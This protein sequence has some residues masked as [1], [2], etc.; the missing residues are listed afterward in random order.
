[1]NVWGR[2]GRWGWDWGC[3]GKNQGMVG[4]RCLRLSGFRVSRRGKA[5]VPFV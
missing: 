5:S 4:I 3:G 2:I 1:M